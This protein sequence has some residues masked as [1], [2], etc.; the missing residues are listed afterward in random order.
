MIDKK[1]T[2][3]G[4]EP[5][6]SVIFLSCEGCAFSDMNRGATIQPPCTLPGSGAQCM[7]RLDGEDI[8]F[9]KVK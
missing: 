3:E 4:F 1:E 7:N 2:Q 9:K 6:D 5:V 8:I